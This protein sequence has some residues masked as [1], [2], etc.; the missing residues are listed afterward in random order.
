LRVNTQPHT[1]ELPPLPD[2]KRVDLTHLP[3]FAIDDQESNDPDDALSLVAP[4]AGG[5]GWAG[6]RLWVHVADVAA[7]V[8]PGSPVDLEARARGVTVYLPEN[9]LSMLPAS[10]RPLLALGLNEVSPALSCGL[11][12]NE[13]GEIINV[14]VVPSWIKVT[15][16]T[17]EQADNMLDQEPFHNLYELALNNENRRYRNGAIRINLPEIKVRIEDGR[18]IIN[19]IISLR[20]RQLVAEAMIMAGEG[21]ARFALAQNIPFPF[22][23]QDPPENEPTFTE[24]IAGMMAVRRTLKRGQ[25]SSIPAPHAG[26]GL[27]VYAQATSPLRRYF[28]LVIH[29]QLRAYLRGEPLLDSAE[30]LERVGTAEVAIQAARQA[31]RLSN[32]HWTLVYLLQNP[33][34]QGEGILIDRRD[35]R[36]RIFIPELD[37]ESWLNLGEELPLNT[38]LFLK[39]KQVKLGRLDTVFKLS[40]KGVP[41]QGVQLL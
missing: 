40:T 15:R 13:A 8:Q 14:E 32:R 35:L 1:L 5:N 29:Q 3:A 37:L 30:L 20:S 31:Q 4:S 24:G 10:A 12:L 6:Y 2:E 39:L 27:D 33:D 11:D 16:L 19:T 28:D 34:W 36:G 18:V 25:I 26:L 38:E 23:T 21:V 9:R 22:A 7:V 17:Y 41:K